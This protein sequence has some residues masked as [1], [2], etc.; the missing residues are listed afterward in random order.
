MTEPRDLYAMLGVAPTATPAEIRQAYRRLVR[1]YH[2][3]RH[4]GDP[5]AHA[6]MVEINAAYAVLSDPDR[7]AAYDAARRR[8]S[9]PRG[10]TSP[11]R[12]APADPGDPFVRLAALLELLEVAVW[13]DLWA[14]RRLLR[15]LGRW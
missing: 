3:D 15:L 11:V 13:A 10:W 12:T 7:R 2:P 4:P 5:A 1:Q 8:P 6:R 14:L 9:T